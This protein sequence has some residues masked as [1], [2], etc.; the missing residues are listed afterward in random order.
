MI[1]IEWKGREMEV[2]DDNGGM[3]RQKRKKM[4]AR[5]RNGRETEEND[6]KRGMKRAINR[7]KR[8]RNMSDRLHVPTV[9]ITI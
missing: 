7:R 8:T 9:H 2:S 6:D 3:K 1:G 4:R 5:E